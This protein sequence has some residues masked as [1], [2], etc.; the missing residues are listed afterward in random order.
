MTRSI[1]IQVTGRAEAPTL[2]PTL[3][4]IGR[5]AD[6]ADDPF[7]P[8]GYLRPTATFDVSASA[9][10][11][12]GAGTNRAHAA[13]DDEIVV[14]ELTDGGTLITSA[15]RL[16]DALQRSHPEWLADD[17]TI[18]LERLR[19]EA[20]APGRGLGEALGG[21]VKKVY[22]L[23]AGEVQGPIIEAALDWLSDHGLKRVELGVTWAGTKALMW[24]VEERLVKDP[25]L[26]RWSGSTA[27]DL[28]VPDARDLEEAAAKK[29]PLLVFVHG[30]GSSTLGSFGDLQRSRSRCLWRALEQ[31]LHG[32][33]L[34]LRA[35]HAVGKPDRERA[36]ARDARCLGARAS[37]WSRIRAAGWSPTCCACRTSTSMI[38]GFAAIA[39]ARHRRRRPRPRGGAGA[40]AQ[41]DERACRTPR[42]VARAVPPAAREAFG[43][44]AL[45]ARRQPGQRHQA[46]ERQLRRLPVGPADADRPACPS[47]S[48]I[49]F[50]A[51]FKRVVIE[52]AQEPHQP[53]PGA[54]HRGD[55]ARLAD[56]R[57][58]ARC[59]GAAGHRDGGDRRRHRGRQPAE[60]PGRAA[61]RLAALR[62]RRQR[63]RGRHRRD[64]G[65]HR[66]AK[67][68]ARVLFDRGRGRLALPLLQQ[69]R[70]RA[71]RCATGWRW[72]SRRR[73]TRFRAAAAELRPASMRPAWPRRARRAR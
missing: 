19:E 37:A 39:F 52:I 68:Q 49:R 61:D 11:A 73:S 50:Y 51:A 28:T 59:A 60:A 23:V 34:R 7:L 22:T 36:A 64:A 53:A 15:G 41:L 4:G 8:S 5:S 18:P 44:R 46:R 31:Q 1:T 69:R 72:T 54:G 65:R 67:S 30:T 3:V 66:A 9:R 47:S 6:A 29:R 57:A 33:H 56:G 2:P 24:A 63:P 25:G 70:A 21:L 32:R 27:N 26:Y 58:A 17:G 20:A 42:A 13:Q 71:A 40:S 12:A 43:D 16:Q 38:D 10:S 48:A 45:R 14:L 55:A 35:P 62:E